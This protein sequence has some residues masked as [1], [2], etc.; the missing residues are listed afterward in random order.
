[1]ANELTLPGRY[2]H[3]DEVTQL[4]SG[5]DNIKLAI[6]EDYRQDPI[7]EKAKKA[8]DVGLNDAAINYI[9]NLTMYDLY[10]KI[11]TYGIEYFSAA[12]NWNGAPLRTIEDLRDVKDY[13][14]ISGAYSLGILPLESHFYLQYCREIRNN[15]STAHY[16]IGEID[17]IELLN[18]IKNCIKYVLTFDLPR[19]GLQIKEL[20][21]KLSAEK[22]SDAETILLTIEGQALKVRGAIMHSLFSLFIK[23]DCDPILK[24]NIRLL[25]PNIWQKLDD[26]IR[27]NVAI[28]YTSLNDVK[29]DDEAKEAK[30]FLT[31]VGGISYIPEANRAIIF[32][33]VAQNFL[34]AHYSWDNFYKEPTYAKDLLSLGKEVPMVSQKSYV[35]SIVMSFVGNSSGVS[36]AAQVYNIKM[37]ESLSQSGVDTVFKLFE[38]DLDL[39]WTMTSSLPA[40][41][42][43]PLMEVLKE[44]TISPEYDIIFKFYIGNDAET[45]KKFFNKRYLE[46]RDKRD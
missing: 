4:S 18:F 13:Q 36:N 12:I 25:A 39:I 38:E 14:V 23:Q 6:R 21:N 27:S 31:M 5:W 16:P 15:F 10:R 46:K 43:Q 1:M 8:C 24:S 3:M 33:Q 35:R 20:V 2:Q 44:K 45:I 32:N 28:R 19:P 29:S 9:W 40:A 30:E 22:V 42:L 26:E 11:C 37:L 34:D 17:N 41:R 7:L